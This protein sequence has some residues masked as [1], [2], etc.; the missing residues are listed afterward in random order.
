MALEHGRHQE[1]LAPYSLGAL[2]ALEAQVLERH[3]ASCTDCRDDLE[4]LRVA[5]DVLPRAVEPID[6]PARLRVSVMEAIAA[7]AGVAVAEP[8]AHASSAPPVRTR[9]PLRA[10][11][12]RRFLPPSLAWAG[13]AVLLLTGVAGGYTASRLTDGEDARTTRTVAAEF[14]RSRLTRGSGSLVVAA[15]GQGAILRVQGVREPAN[16]KVYELWLD[17]GG[18]MIPVSL[19]SVDSKGTGLG[20]IE[21]DL[22]DVDAVFVTREPLG[23]S[24]APT[25][26]PIMRVDLGKR[27]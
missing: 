9:E 24:R 23:G 5:A 8:A 11:I 6:P 26:E 1:N 18:E 12:A 21:G 25:E 10:R 16:G 14:D 20:A 2:T 13:A 19:F 22:K 7:E 17:R 4:R 3:L 27:S 15:D